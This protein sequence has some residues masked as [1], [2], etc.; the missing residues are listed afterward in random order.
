MAALPSDFRTV[1]K[2]WNRYIDYKGNMSNVGA[3]CSTPT[4]DAGISLIAEFELFGVRKYANQ[5]EQD[6]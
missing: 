1:L 5:N 4:V 3:N 6:Y 2:L